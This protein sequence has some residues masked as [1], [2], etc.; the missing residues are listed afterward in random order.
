MSSRSNSVETALT[1]PRIILLDKPAASLNQ[2]EQAD[3]AQRLRRVA[4][5]A[6]AVLVIEHNMAFFATLVG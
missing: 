3:L 6:V 5:D 4:W 1:Q 2:T